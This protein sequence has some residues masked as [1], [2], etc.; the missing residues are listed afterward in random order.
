[1]INDLGTSAD[2]WKYVDDISVSEIVER[3]RESEL[4]VSVVNF[5]TQS[6]R[7]GFHLSETKCKNFRIGFSNTT[8]DFDPIVLNGKP[9]EIITS[10][11]LLGLNL[12]SD[13]KWNTHTSERIRRASPRQYFLRQLKRCQVAPKELTVFYTTYIRPILE[14]ACPVFHRP[15][16]EYLSDDLERIQRRALK[17]IHSDLSYSE[18]LKV[19]VLQRLHERRESITTRLYHEVTNNPFH[20]LHSLLPK[21]NGC[22]YSLRNKRTFVVPRCKT[23][24]FKNSFFLSQLDS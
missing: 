21:R 4:Q 2:M 18:A 24:R 14:Y 6:S 9:L 17:I 22:K 1:M 7:E 8:S 23:D 20:K 15:L 11:K 19:S 16:P 13:L 12:T 10:A 5:A 3:G